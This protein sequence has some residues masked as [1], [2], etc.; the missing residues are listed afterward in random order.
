MLKYEYE[1]DMKKRDTFIILRKLDLF[2]IL[3]P[4][5]KS[6]VISFALEQIL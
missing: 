3:L 2:L 6:S 1:K 4:Y 5:D